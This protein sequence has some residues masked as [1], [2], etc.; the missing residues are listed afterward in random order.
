MTDS[1]DGQD[2]PRFK[3]PSVKGGLEVTE[4]KFMDWRKA[5]LALALMAGR[6]PSRE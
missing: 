5:F 1:P 6:I 2:S 4:R 3:K